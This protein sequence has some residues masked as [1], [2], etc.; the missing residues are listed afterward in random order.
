ME[1]KTIMQNYNNLVD[2]LYENYNKIT[3]I[4]TYDWDAGKPYTIFYLN[5]KDSFD[6]FKDDWNKIKEDIKEMDDFSYDD[7][8]DIFEAKTKNKYDYIELASVNI[9]TT[10]VYELEI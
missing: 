10:S 4:D 1:N 5:K 6:N 8:L 7:I 9:Y 3:V 2:A